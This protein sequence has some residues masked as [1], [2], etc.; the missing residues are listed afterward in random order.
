MEFDKQVSLLKN[1]LGEA[2]VDVKTQPHFPS[3]EVKLE[4][5]N[6]ALELSRHNLEL[7]YDILECITPFDTAQDLG[8]IY[9]LF[10]SELFHRLNIKVFI[11]RYKPIVPSATSVWSGA[12]YYEREA[13]E[14]FGISFRVGAKT[15]EDARLFLPEGWLGFP[16]RKDYVYPNM[17]GE[18]EHRRNPLRKERVR[19]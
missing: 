14:M 17:V 9:Q 8:L 11:D 6:N 18:L 13:T 12:L 2:I 3:V 4:F 15:I 10:S 19:P 7:K 16:M 1:I 5:L